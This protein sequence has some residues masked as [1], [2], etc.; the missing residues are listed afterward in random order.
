M[1]EATCGK[2]TAGLEPVLERPAS[3][4]WHQAEM[5]EFKKEGTT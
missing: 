2:G 5:A 4:S 1:H 3:L